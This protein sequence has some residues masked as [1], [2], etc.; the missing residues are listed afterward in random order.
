M[1]CM[2]EG[3]LRSCLKCVTDDY[4]LIGKRPVEA[5]LASAGGGLGKGFSIRPSTLLTFMRLSLAASLPK[6]VA[7]PELRHMC[8]N[9][10]VP[11]HPRFHASHPSEPSASTG[12]CRKVISLTYRWLTGP[13][14]AG[15][16]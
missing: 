5:L 14:A 16:N 6:R 12:R 9:V 2:P 11:N 4:G 1:A 7:P 15:K 3:S 13:S 8:E 10:Y